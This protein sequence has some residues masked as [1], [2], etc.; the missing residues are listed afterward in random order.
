MDAL[1]TARYWR[2]LGISTIPIQYR[3]KRPDSAKLKGA[4]WEP[5][6]TRLPSDTE[7]QVWFGGGLVNIGLV[8]GMQGLTVIDFDDAGEYS[9]W[10]MWATNY[11]GFTRY[12]AETT[13]TVTTAR[14]AH[15]YV[16]L[17]YTERNRHMPG[18]DIKASRG[19]VLT[20]PSIHP[21]GKEYSVLHDSFPALV[22]ALSDVLP[23]DLL[24]ANVDLPAGV[25]LPVTLTPATDPWSVAARGFD[26]SMDLVHTIR[27]EIPI[28]SL[29]PGAIRSSGDGRWMMAVCPFHDDRD[30]SMWIDTTR[31][32]CG[33]Y[34]GCTPKPLD[35]I[36]LYGR[37]HGLSN[38]E[39][40]FALAQA[41]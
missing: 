28:I 8:V 35:V 26:P 14:G 3:D 20:P 37:L 19:Y 15:V 12:I 10:L 5:Y 2:S 24:T 4:G 32:I 13:F 30:P 34:A 21:S 33:C 1:E 22:E 18:I 16:R 27:N 36:N 31:G 41:R 7:L 29:F 17:P 39:A 9:R 23:P 25:H 38:R 40:I 11:A 6:M